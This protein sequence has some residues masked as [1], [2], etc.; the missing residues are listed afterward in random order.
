MILSGAFVETRC[1]GEFRVSAN[2]C[3]QLAFC[4]C[5]IKL[6]IELDLISIYLLTF[7]RA[8]ECKEDSG[9]RKGA[10]SEG[11]CF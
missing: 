3:I 5:D 6:E 11:R 7:V 4:Y 10:I 2:Q 1:V 8:A 9:R